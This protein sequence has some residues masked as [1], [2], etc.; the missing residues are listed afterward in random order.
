[1]R[2]AGMNCNSSCVRH[3]LNKQNR[4]RMKP[5]QTLRAAVLLLSL[6]ACSWSAVSQVALTVVSSTN[7][8]SGNLQISG[9]Y[10][11]FANDSGSFSICDI[12]DP[13]HPTIVGQAPSS[14]YTA[15]GLAVSSQYAYLVSDAGLKIYDVS[16]PN[17]PVLIGSTNLTGAPR[18]IFVSNN[19]AYISGPGLSVY[20]VSDP[21][22]PTKIGQTSSGS[23]Y[24]GVIVGNNAFLTLPNSGT[25]LFVYDIT[26][27]SAPTKI[28]TS[29][30]G[31]IWGVAVSGD[32]LFAASEFAYGNSGAH[33]GLLTLNISNPANPV[34]VN[35]AS[36]SLGAGARVVV[37]G[38]YVYLADYLGGGALGSGTLKVYDISNPTNLVFAGQISGIGQAFGLAVSDNHVYMSTRTGFLVIAIIPQL[39]I[40]HAG[41]SNIR[42]SWPM[43]G[44]FSLQQ[45]TDLSAGNWTTLTN[46]PTEVG[47]RGQVLLL[48]PSSNTYFRL[49]S[50]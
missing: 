17:N 21:A 9:H 27:P 43:T 42:L 34:V 50:Q 16:T 7:I 4:L 28:Y 10:L 37:A 26:T 41:V 11:Y 35:S 23:G 40:N 32:F 14:P 25:T 30:G 19:I 33:S 47:A 20:D 31:Y 8:T 39:T 13:T 45:I 29:G 22:N 12:S 2:A 38:K 48:N 3:I 15:Y 6:S 36:N 49:V 24:Y 18:S 46:T 1:M 44:P 5:I